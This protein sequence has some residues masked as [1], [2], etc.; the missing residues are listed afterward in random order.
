M[1]LVWRNGE[2]KQM[3][4]D[5]LT[6]RNALIDRLVGAKVAAVKAAGGDVDSRRMCVNQPSRRM[7]VNQPSRQISTTVE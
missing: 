3:T 2:I 7:C 5:A 1:V 6:I 4:K